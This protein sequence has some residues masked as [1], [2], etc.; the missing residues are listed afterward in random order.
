MLVLHVSDTHLGSSAPRALPFRYRD[1]LEAFVETVDIAIRERVDIY[2]HAGDFFDRAYAPPDTYL[3]AIK[4]LKRLKDSGIRVVVIAGQHDLPRRYG[5]SPILLLKELGVADYVAVS[6]IER[7]EVK[8]RSGTIEVVAIPF[9]KRQSLKE[10]P[11]PRNAKRSILLAHL[12]LKEVV[13]QNPDASLAT[14]PQGFSYVALGDYHGY[15]VFRLNDGT[16]VVYPGATEVFRRDEWSEG[17]KGVVLVDL[18][19]EEPTIHRV[20][21]ESVRPWIIES[22]SSATEA[23]RDVGERAKKLVS[24]GKK[25][26]LVFISLASPRE[27]VALVHHALEALREQNLVAYYHVEV[28]KEPKLASLEPTIELQYDGEKLDLKKLVA[29]VVGSS[30]LAEL[31]MELVTNPSEYS[32]KKL[33]ENLK[34]DPQLLEE[35]KKFV[36]RGPLV[37]KSGAPR[38]THV[39]QPLSQRLKG[40][41]GLMAF[42]KR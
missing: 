7:F 13:P 10:A 18:S 15:R 3:V 32:A 23:I 31:L 20:V 33:I 25:P 5:M 12:L 21:L 30:K 11:R 6:S 41:S 38:A 37:S 24:E 17:G 16:P 35:A 36:L 8:C 29:Q 27:G 39:E 1:V 14:I 26:P 42:L 34:N 28:S 40:K 19:S 2:L 4:H 22:Y 9:P